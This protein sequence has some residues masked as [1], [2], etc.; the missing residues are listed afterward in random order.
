MSTRKFTI[1]LPNDVDRMA[2]QAAERAHLPLSAWLAQAA[3]RSAIEE[4]ALARGR[5]SVEAFLA[6]EGPLVLSPEDEAWVEETLRMSGINVP[7]E[8][9]PTK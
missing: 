4:E 3:R 9:A 6:E 7:S 2:R 5:A 8:K 1:S